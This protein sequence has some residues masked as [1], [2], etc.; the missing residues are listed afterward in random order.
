LT[1]FFLPHLAWAL[2]LAFFGI[3]ESRVVGD[4]FVSEWTD[5]EKVLPLKDRIR[6]VDKTR[7]AVDFVIDPKVLPEVARRVEEKWASLS[8]EFLSESKSAS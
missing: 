5:I 2:R 7:G 6:L 1:V 8:P 3:Y 4:Q